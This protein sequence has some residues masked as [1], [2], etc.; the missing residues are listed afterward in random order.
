MQS[1][2]RTME[3]DCWLK[4]RRALQARQG[5]ACCHSLS[6]DFAMVAVAMLNRVQHVADM[7]PLA[8]ASVSR[9]KGMC[10]VCRFT[11]LAGII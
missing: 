6:W 2:V 5:R 9:C 11:V 7:V 10:T 3:V 4:P 1:T 8:L